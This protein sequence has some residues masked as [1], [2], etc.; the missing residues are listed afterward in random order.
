MAELDR[1][2]AELI[3]GV[4]R[5]YIS[6]YMAKY[7]PGETTLANFEQEDMKVY[8]GTAPV[9]HLTIR[10]LVHAVAAA[11]KEKS[12][13]NSATYPNDNPLFVAGQTNATFNTS[14]GVAAFTIHDH[15]VSFSKPVVI[16]NLLLGEEAVALIQAIVNNMAETDRNVEIM[17]N[18]IWD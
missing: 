15:S 9:C 4:V 13:A 12:Q 16:D 3:I 8:S 1:Q 7:T 14:M 18:N 6:N 11:I 10:K 5:E 2:T 17:I